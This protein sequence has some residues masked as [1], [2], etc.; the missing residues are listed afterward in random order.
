MIG[1]YKITNVLNGKVYIGQSIDIETRWKQHIDEGKRLRHKTK[2]YYAMNEYGIDNFHFE[3][4]ELCESNQDI[5]NQKER[6]WINYYDSYNNGYNSTLGGQGEDSWIYN[7]KL[8]QKL[9][10]EGYTVKEIQ[11]IIGCGKTLVNLRLTGYKDYNAHTSHRRSI[12]K[13]LKSDKRKLT[14]KQLQ[15][16]GNSYPVHQ[17]TLLGEYVAS[18]PSQE[19]AATDNNWSSPQNIGNCI[20]KGHKTAYGYQWSKIKVDKMSPVVKPHSK[21]I[22]CIETSEIF[23]S[24]ASAAEWCGLKS[25]HNINDCCAGRTKSAGKHPKTGEKLHWKWI[26]VN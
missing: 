14:K 26:N 18:Y 17:Y 10:D 8:I 5:L 21:L 9:W 15:Y 1:I 4:I 19:Q 13:K 2:L 12:Y 16:F 7:P 3:I 6:Y 23:P 11:D 25:L 20:T 22:Q 24:S